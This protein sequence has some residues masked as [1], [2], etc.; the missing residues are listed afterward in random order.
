M[1]YTFFFANVVG[2]QIT[3]AA[4][5]TALLAGLVMLLNYLGCSV[6]YVASAALMA[7]IPFVIILIVLWYIVTK[8]L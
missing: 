5:T 3:R 8:A 1:F 2:K 6:I 4:L 7:Y